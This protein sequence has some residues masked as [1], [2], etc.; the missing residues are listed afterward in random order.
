MNGKNIEK[1][2]EK[3][4]E[5]N[6]G[7]LRTAE[8][9]SAGISKDHFYK[10]MKQ[11]GFEKYAHGIYVSPDTLTDEKYLI[12]VRFPKAVYS[13]DASLYLH[14]LAEYEPIPLKVTVP[15]SYN[16]GGLVRKGIQ[17]YYVRPE[18]YA[19]GIMQMPSADGHM[20]KVY[21]LERTICD[22]VR[23]YESMDI[24]V[25]NYAA[26]EYMNRSDK[27]LV[28]LGQYASKMHMEKKLRD[29]MGVLF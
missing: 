7:V 8:A 12:Q 17:V 1:I 4:S 25:F 26:R 23:R 24:S 13:H 18:W 22:I 5:E 14:D 2:L 6:N 27:N 21:D 15:A 10:Y 9:T 16:S 28:K 20:L 11:K 3:L 29:K 19:L